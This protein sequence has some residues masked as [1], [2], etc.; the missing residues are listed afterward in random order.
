MSP[1]TPGGVPLKWGAA[2]MTSFV[3]RRPV[4]S[5]LI[6]VLLVLTVLSFVLP[7]V[8]GGGGGITH[9]FPKSPDRAQ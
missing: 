6:V 5:G 8:G 7:Y 3:K 1:S 2:E 4:V 9:I